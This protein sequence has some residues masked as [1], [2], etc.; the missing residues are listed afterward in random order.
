MLVSPQG[1]EAGRGNESAPLVNKQNNASGWAIS[2]NRS[3]CRGDWFAVMSGDQRAGFLTEDVY[4]SAITS[5]LK[6]TYCMKC[7][8]EKKIKKHFHTFPSLPIFTA[9]FT[10]RHVRF[11]PWH[12][13]H[14]RAF[15]FFSSTLRGALDSLS[16]FSPLSTASCSLL[17][18]PGPR[19]YRTAAR[20]GSHEPPPARRWP[21]STRLS[22]PL[23]AGHLGGEEG[24]KVKKDREREN[25]WEVKVLRGG[26]RKQEGKKGEKIWGEKEVRDKERAGKMKAR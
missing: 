9:R 4:P 10:T 16:T 25:E 22:L 6:T 26:W 23:W 17:V 20:R 5:P 21:G 18:S 11:P 24:R 3:C 2:S 8:F 7:L 13:I 1:Y 14:T 12:V 19:H 15:I